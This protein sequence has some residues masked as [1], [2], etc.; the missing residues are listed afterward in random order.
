MKEKFIFALA[1]VLAAT[2]TTDARADDVCSAPVAT[3]AG[4]VAGVGEPDAAACGYKGMAYAAPPVGPLRFRPPQPPAPHADV[5]VAD[6]FSPWCMQ[7]YHPGILDRNDRSVP[8]GEDCLYLNVWRPEKSGVFPVMFF[9]H[10]GGFIGGSGATGM[11]QGER[12]AAAEDV[13]VVTINY[14][15]GA[16]GF[17]A[18]PALAAEAG[19][20]G[21]GNYGLLDQLAALRWV[22]DNIAGFGGDPGNVTIFGESAG[23]WSVCSLLASPLATGLFHRAII[24]SGGCDVAKTTAEAEADGRAFAAGLACDGPGA[25]DC[26]RQKSADEILAAQKATKVDNLFDLRA[27]MRYQWIPVIDGR[28]LTETPI[29]ALRGGRAAAV[30]LLVGSNRDELKIFTFDYPGIRLL[31]AVVVD[32]VLRET[33]GPDALAEIHRL[34]PFAGRRPMDAAIEAVGDATMTCKCFD[35]AE[36][37]APRAPVWYYRFDYDD[38]RAPHLYG[39]GHALELPFIFDTFDQRDFD[40]F[41]SAAQARRAQALSRPM[42]RYWADFARTG[43]PNGPGLPAWPR[44]DDGRGRMYFDLPLATRPTDNVEKCGFWERQGVSLK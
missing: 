44:Y 24:Q 1:M 29:A 33:F 14:R 5:Q 11:Y 39:A 18:H 37:Q 16:F 36:A 30:P 38:H 27:M 4:P 13:V 2:L 9:I 43:D 12:L 20:E 23:G 3:A 35:A 41:F 8:T 6:A 10:G 21:E 22:R 31:P 19:Q 15:L 28:A 42:M 26:L 40:V 32:R 17:L 34:Y 7:R 25:A